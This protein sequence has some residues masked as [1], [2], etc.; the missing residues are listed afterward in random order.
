V[1]SSDPGNTTGRIIE[2]LLAIANATL[3][4]I[5]FLRGGR[6]IFRPM[7]EWPAGTRR[8]IRSIR[9]TTVPGGGLR[10]VGVTLEDP[11]KAKALLRRLGVHPDTH[12]LDSP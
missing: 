2:H 8:A 3:D 11:A 5:S 9:T 4:Q 10:V 1:N 6:R 12:D 7:E